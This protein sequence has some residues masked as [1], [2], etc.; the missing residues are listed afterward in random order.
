MQP[1]RGIGCHPCGRPDLQRLT[2][3]IQGSAL[4]AYNPPTRII[5]SCV[6]SAIARS[7]VI[8]ST[9]VIVFAAA[10]LFMRSLFI[11]HFALEQKKSFVNSRFQA[12]ES[13]SNVGLTDC[14]T[15]L[16]VVQEIRLNRVSSFA[17][18]SLALASSCWF[19]V[20]GGADHMITSSLN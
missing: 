2:A 6:F 12:G 16:L 14:G 8:L 11:W 19:T 7:S 15:V 13:C 4:S 10:L 20:L 1:L 17:R 9:M 3:H 18:R 5:P